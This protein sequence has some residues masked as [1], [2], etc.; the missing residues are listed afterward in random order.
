MT[1]LISIPGEAMMPEK[2]TATLTSRGGDWLAVF[3][4]GVNDYATFKLFMPD[5]YSGGGVDVTLTLVTEA[6]TSG[7]LDFDLQM[8]KMDGE[9]PDSD[10]FSTAVSSDNNTVPGTNIRFDIT[11]SLS[12]GSQMDSVTGGE[13]FLL[14]VTRDGASDTVADPVQLVGLSVSE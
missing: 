2:S 3:T 4:E 5:A 13:W 11:I 9:S 6:S 1:T 12:D 8:E 10:S 14:R 7:D